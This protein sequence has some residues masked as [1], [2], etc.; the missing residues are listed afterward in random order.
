MMP[1]EQKIL[2]FKHFK[3]RGERVFEQI[4]NGS[5]TKFVRCF[6]TAQICK[7]LS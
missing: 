3:S 4:K 6:I 2:K 5:R 7:K 1:N